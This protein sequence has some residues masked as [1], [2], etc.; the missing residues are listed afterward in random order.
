MPQ[1]H[2]PSQ[3]LK[4]ARGF[5]K[6]RLEKL[7]VARLRHYLKRSDAPIF[8]RYSALDRLEQRNT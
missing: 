4:S 6:I 8:R 5:G 7:S 2:S 3:Q 1:T